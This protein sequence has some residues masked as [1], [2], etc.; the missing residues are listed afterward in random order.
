YASDHGEMLGDHGRWGKS[1][2]HNA[3][4]GVPLIVS[5]PQAPGGRVSQALVSLHDLAATFLDYAGA[6][7]LPEMEARSLRP[8]LEG[9]AADGD[10]R[11]VAVC[12][13]GDWRLVVDGRHKLVS[14]RDGADLLYDRVDD[15]WEDRDLAAERP[16]V[17]GRLRSRLAREI[18]G[19]LAWS[20]AERRT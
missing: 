18:P 9:G 13:L 15:P 4:A 2:W 5:V 3:A 16:E 11:E 19:W 7:P 10:H 14:R 6:R 12:G 8:V 17:V 1:T 20:P